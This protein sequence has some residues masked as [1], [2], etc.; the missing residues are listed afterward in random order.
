MT[1]YTELMNTIIKFFGILFVF[2]FV[3]GAAT[4]TQAQ[5]K[6]ESGVFK[7]AE[8]FTSAGYTFMNNFVVES[9][10]RKTEDD[11]NGQEWSVVL[12]PGRKYRFSLCCYAGIEDIVLNLY[13]DTTP[14]AT[15]ICSTFTNGKD[16]AY[17]D[18]VSQ[19]EG[20]YKLSIRFKP[21][22]GID[23]KLCAI[24]M[25]GYGGKVSK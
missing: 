7:C 23:K 24:G 3:L 4:E 12:L 13:N 2:A 14:E 6:D 15:P 21:G 8:M 25:L 18:Y 9:K 10:K 20:A 17:F 16:A 5:C 11:P 19:T 22:K 1:F